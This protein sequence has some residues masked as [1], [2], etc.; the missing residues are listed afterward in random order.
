MDKINRAVIV[1]N[2]EICDFTFL[3]NDFIISCD[4]ALKFLNSIGRK[5]DVILGDFDSLGYVPENAYVF[6]AEKDFTDGELALEY[7]IEKSIKEVVFICGGGRR[8][9]HFLGNL[10]L[11]IKADNNGIKAKI[12]TRYSTIY[13]V[14]EPTRFDGLVVGT[15]FSVI[16]LEESVVSSQEGLKYPYHKSLQIDSTFG[17][18]NVVTKSNVILGVTSGRVLVFVNKTNE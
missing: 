14:K 10:A 13:I 8:E 6:P 16:P 3:K 7:C 4:G 12:E 15:T 9:D 1:L 5:P 11:L 2:G 18:S 17:V